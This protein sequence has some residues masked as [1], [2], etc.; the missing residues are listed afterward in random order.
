TF[1]HGLVIVYGMEGVSGCK[2]K[3]NIRNIPVQALEGSCDG[4]ARRESEIPDH[5]I[6]AGLCQLGE[7]L[8]YRTHHGPG[9]DIEEEVCVDHVD[10]PVFFI[11]EDSGMHCLDRM[12]EM[13]ARYSSGE[14]IQHGIRE[15]DDSD[16][17]TP[18]GRGNGIG[19]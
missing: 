11:L 8:D 13:P 5:H 9:E 10:L 3:E 17:C 4:S 1:E 2:H 15:I 14:D 12:K 7:V 16:P 19:P 18:L 6:T